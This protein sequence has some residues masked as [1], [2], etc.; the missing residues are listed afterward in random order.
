MANTYLTRSLSST[1]T[2]WTF[3]AWVKRS[4]ISATSY[5]IS[6]GSNGTDGT[7]IG[8]NSSDDLFYYTEGTGSQ[9]KTSAKYRDTNGFYHVVV[10]S[11]SNAITLYINGEEPTQAWTSGSN[12]VAWNGRYKYNANRKMGNFSLLP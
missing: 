6:W 7:G 12:G 9:I 5:L 2:S 4:G 11:N 10:K 1:N 3:S 8:F